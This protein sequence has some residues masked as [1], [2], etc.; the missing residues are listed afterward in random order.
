MAGI[1]SKLQYIA[2]VNLVVMMPE[3]L[4]ELKNPVNSARPGAAESQLPFPN[5]NDGSPMQREQA[6][7]N[8]GRSSRKEDV[9]G[10]EDVD[11]SDSATAAAA[12]A[13]GG[14]YNRAKKPYLRVMQRR[15]LAEFITHGNHGI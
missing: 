12:A 5:P 13:P 4:R 1:I 2:T 11:G 7:A 15:T 6:E 9:E 3:V 8:S 10:A 14:T